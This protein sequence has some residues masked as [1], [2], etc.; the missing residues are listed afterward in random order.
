MD[1]LP[2]LWNLDPAV[3]ADVL[4]SGVGRLYSTEHIGLLQILQVLLIHHRKGSRQELGEGVVNGV[5]L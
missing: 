3:F 1:K 2:R 4:F 5:M